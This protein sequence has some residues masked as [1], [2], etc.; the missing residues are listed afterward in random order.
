M[1]AFYILTFHQHLNFLK[2]LQFLLLAC[3]ILSCSATKISNKQVH[4][5]E[6]GNSLSAEEFQNRWRDPDIQYTRWDYMSDTARVATLSHPVYQR[7]EISYSSFRYNIEKITGKEIPENTIFL[8]DYTYLDDLCSSKST[9]NWKKNVVK[10]R[11]NFLN[12]IKAK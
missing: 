5:D 10:S 12:P 1:G 11:K 8:L 4:L 6:K 7:L 3:L 9:N 2:L